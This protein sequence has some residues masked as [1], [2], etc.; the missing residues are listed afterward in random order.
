MWVEKALLFFLAIGM[1]APIIFAYFFSGD[2]DNLDK[3]QS[4]LGIATAVITTLF[5]VI[6]ALLFY[7][8]QAKSDVFVPLVLVLCFINSVLTTIGLTVNLL[9]KQ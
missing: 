2:K 9:V 5:V 6:Y 3:V 8:V 4:A 1:T 7:W